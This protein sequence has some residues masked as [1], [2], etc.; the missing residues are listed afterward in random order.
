MVVIAD[1]ISRNLKI[2]LIRFG[3]ISLLIL[4]VQSTDATCMSGSVNASASIDTSAFLIGDWI[5]VEVLLEHPE[6]TSITSLTGDTL[7]PLLV[8]KKDPVQRLSKEKSVTGFRIAAYDTGRVTI[9]PLRFI[10]SLPSDSVQK[11]IETTPIDLVIHSIPVDTTHDIKDIKEPVSL[12]LTWKEMVTPLFIVMAIIATVWLL[13]RYLK[14][15][16]RRERTPVEVI[17]TRPPHIVAIEKLNIIEEKRLWQQGLIKPYYS[18]VTEV[19]RGYLDGRYRIHA[20]ELTTDEI[21]DYIESVDMPSGTRRDLDSMLNLADL[22]KFA[23]YKALPDENTDTLRMAFS[24]VEN[25]AEVD[26]DRVDQGDQEV[27]INVSE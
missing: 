7:G 27:E 23:R 21:L 4:L 17:D 15:R 25:T 6:G 13:F 3:T 14:K 5:D 2:F 20:L 1:K 24:V 11:E 10:Y 9:P 16:G 22:V 26:D 12:A 8:L 19:I 18:E